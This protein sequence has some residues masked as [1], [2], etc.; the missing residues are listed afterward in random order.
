L[1]AQLSTNRLSDFIVNGVSDDF[2][3][4]IASEKK[5]ESTRP[6][7]HHRPGRRVAGERIPQRPHRACR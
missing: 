4:V 3:G 6:E 5:V 7:L 1:G 2:R